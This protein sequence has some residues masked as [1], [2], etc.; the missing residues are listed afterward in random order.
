MENTTTAETVFKVA[1]QTGIAKEKYSKFA[2]SE[3]KAKPTSKKVDKYC[4][5]FTFSG[6]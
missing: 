4:R 2:I 6:R 5:D 1:N 3:E